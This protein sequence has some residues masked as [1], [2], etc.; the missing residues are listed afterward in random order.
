MGQKSPV[1]VQHTQK[2][3]ELTGGFVRV[4]VLLTGY[5]SAQRLGTLGGGFVS[6]EGDLGCSEDTFRRVD[7]NPVLLKPFE[8]WKTNLPRA[9]LLAHLD[10]STPLALVIDASM[11][12]LG[13]LLQQR[14]QNDGSPSSI[15]PRKST[16]R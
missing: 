6:V 5:S 14:V 7:E 1:E 16:P 13:A 12:A 4:A 9:T 10:P 8:E 15:T 2:T 11:A 3:V